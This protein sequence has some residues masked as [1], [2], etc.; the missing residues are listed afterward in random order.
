MVALSIHT[1]TVIKSPSTERYVSPRRGLFTPLRRDAS[2]Y[3]DNRS[4]N[5]NLIFGQVWKSHGSGRVGRFHKLS[6]VGSPLSDPRDFYRTREQPRTQVAKTAPADTKQP[7]FVGYV[8]THMGCISHTQSVPT[9]L[10]I[11]VYRISCGLVQQTH[12]TGGSYVI[13]T[14]SRMDS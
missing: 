10:N 14:S 9:Q 8:H 13:E 3:F 2:Y 6:R 4:H 11:H 5:P 7:G 1:L 12:F